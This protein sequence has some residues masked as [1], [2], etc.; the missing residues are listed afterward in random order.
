MFRT[1][2]PRP[3][4]IREE[5][6]NLNGEWNFD[7][8][9]EKVGLKERWHKT[10]KQYTKKINVPFVFQTELSGIKDRK[11]HDVVWYNR[12]FEVPEKWKNKRVILNFG[13]VDYSCK[14]FINE[15]LV[16]EHEGGHVSFSFD[17]TD[18]L[19]WG[20][21]DITIFVEDPSTDETIPRGKQ[22]WKEKS[23]SIWYTRTT[24]IW[25][26]VWLEPVGSVSLDYVR[27]TPDIDRGNIEVEFEPSKVVDGLNALLEISFKGKV[28]V[29]ERIDV[30]E[31]YNSAVINLFNKKIFRSFSHG[32][33]WCWT[34][35]EPNLFDINI[36]LY[37][38]EKV[39]DE[40]KSYFGM[41]KIHTEK[42]LVYLNNRPYY[43]KLVLDQG[44]W[45]EGLLTA[46][47]DEDF[48]TDIKLAKEMGFNGCRKHQKVEDPRFLYWADK[49]GFLV[50]GETANA[51][52][53]S[54]A[55][56]E[57]LTKE[58][59]EI[60]KRDYNHPCIVAWVPLNESWGV[61]LIA[62]DKCQQNHSLAMY[63][64]THSLDRTRLVISNDG[65]EL[66]KT[67]ICA[68]HNYN[69]GTK[70]EKEKYNYFIE[71]LKIKEAV[72]SSQP[73]GRGIYAE[74][75]E[76]QGE[77]ILL[78]EFGGIAYDMTN[79]E[80]WGYTVAKTEEEFLSDYE[81]VVSAVLASNIIYGFCYTQLTDV[82]QEVN[83]LLTYDRK[84]KCS[85]EKIKEINNKWRMNVVEF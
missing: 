47:K 78:T 66:T 26:T 5:W 13:A 4:F 35:E 49:L 58:W 34:P 40:V 69:H 84:P 15:D 57:R 39:Y 51:A 3:N 23:A 6:L 46:P 81:R 9:D 7:F 27:L 71:S 56:V 22:F 33:G 85:L 1:E 29:R 17:I 19:T 65:W 70:D 74:G 67:D 41:R 53:Y 36:K 76:H 32:N 54:N 79:P 38:E 11:F 64:L 50:W 63:H 62:K 44:Y 14:V 80:G 8:D 59:M 2:Y 77:P 73:A 10:R 21:E 83:G 43:Q 30:M 31:K 20:Q 48:V 18:Y 61:P 42:G 24:G 16:G 55:A 60:I 75:F 72:L 12:K 37:V 52:E 45:S 68:V 28:V 25:Q 82:E